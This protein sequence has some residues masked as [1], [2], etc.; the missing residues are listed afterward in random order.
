V[1]R[2]EQL[3]LDLR[4]RLRPAFVPGGGD[5]D[6]V[7]EPERGER[8]LGGR[9]QEGEAAGN[10][11]AE[12]HVE[13]P[14]TLPPRDRNLRDRTDEVRDVD[15][16]RSSSTIRATGPPGPALPKPSSGTFAAAEATSVPCHGHAEPPLQGTLTLRRCGANVDPGGRS[17]P[18]GLKPTSTIPIGIRES[19]FAGSAK[20]PA[21]ASRF[22]AAPTRSSGCRLAEK[23]GQ[24]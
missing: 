13:D 1:R 15:V 3:A 23:P 8:E 12:A 21:R 11:E 19:G 7:R 20:R 16:P 18:F 24:R 10:R 22:H 17:F 14:D 5:E 4:G 9:R 2:G 6:R